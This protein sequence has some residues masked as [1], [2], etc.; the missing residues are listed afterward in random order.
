[1][2]FIKEKGDK[3]KRKYEFPLNFLVGKSIFKF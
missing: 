3:E 2:I 1:M